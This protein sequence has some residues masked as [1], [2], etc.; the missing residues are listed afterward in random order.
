M[1]EDHLPI[2][3][4]FGIL[5]AMLTILTAEICKTKVCLHI[6]HAIVHYICFMLG[7]QHLPQLDYTMSY[8]KATT[9]RPSKPAMPNRPEP[10]W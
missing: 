4:L 10:V 3:P 7:L 5:L 9:A 2:P 6:N 8:A 1:N